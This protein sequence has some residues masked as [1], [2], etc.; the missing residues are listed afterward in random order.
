MVWMQTWGSS[1]PKSGRRRKSG[2][3][4][5]LPG[6]LLWMECTVD[7]EMT[8]SDRPREPE[9]QPRETDTH[10]HQ[11]AHRPRSGSHIVGKHVELRKRTGGE[12]QRQEAF[13]TRSRVQSNP[14][15]GLTGTEAPRRGAQDQVRTR[16]GRLSQSYQQ[17]CE[18]KLDTYIYIYIYISPCVYIYIYIYIYTYI[19]SSSWKRS[20]GFLTV[21]IGETAAVL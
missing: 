19:L 10:Q 12:L 16:R 13:Q 21:S 8:D 7:R 18:T 5:R 14:S 17:A 9:N 15:Q 1:L 6:T 2:A 3:P 4:G 20:G 11:R